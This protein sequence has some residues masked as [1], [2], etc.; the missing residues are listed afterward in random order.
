MP[1]YKTVNNNK[2]GKLSAKLAEETILN[3]LCVDII[4]PYKNV[5]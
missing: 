1:M 5:L 4:G 2:N 3:K